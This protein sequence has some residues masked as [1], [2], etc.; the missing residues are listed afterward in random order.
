MKTKLLS[1]ILLCLISISIS[2]QTVT[3]TENFNNYAGGNSYSGIPIGSGQITWTLTN[4]SASTIS[5]NAVKLD[6]KANTGG[7]AVANIPNGISGIFSFTAT[8]SVNQDCSLSI[9]IE[10]T[11]YNITIPQNTTAGN[12]SFS[13]TN[14]Q[15]SEFSL[16]IENTS[17]GSRS[18]TIDDITWSGLSTIRE[19]Q[20]TTSP[21]DDGTFPSPHENSPFTLLGTVTGVIE[22]VGYY[23]Q[24]EAAEWSGIW[25]NDPSLNPE[26]LDEVL[27]TG[28]IEENNGRTE[29]GAISSSSIEGINT[30][31]EP[32]PVLIYSPIDESLESVVSKIEYSRYAT[33]DAGNIVM[34]IGFTAPLTPIS[35]D[36]ALYTMS[37]PDV[38]NLYL[39]TGVVNNA[40]GSFSLSP[41]DLPDVTDQGIIT[42]SIHAQVLKTSITT[43]FSNIIAESASVYS[44]MIYNLAGQKVKELNG[45]EGRTE[46][47]VE[48]GVY[49]V[50]LNAASISLTEKVLVK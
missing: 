24:D 43:S 36:N 47:S 6:I 21:G 50:R 11:P 34:N 16:E 48:K 1:F 20:Y 4:A 35:I 14:P 31:S 42:S 8:N 22:N 44:L 39:I 28:T 7:K 33:G 41:R 19:I 30:G 38:N 10:G 9:S 5:G 29:L 37:N 17:G 13:V 25:I 23:I 3:R 49:I 45:M 32:F 2:A 12:F 40:T 26:R 27:V 18:V 46:I 15:N